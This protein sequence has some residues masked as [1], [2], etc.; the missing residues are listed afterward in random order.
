MISHIRCCHTVQSLVLL[1]RSGVLRCCF[2]LVTF[3]VKSVL[4]VDSF[5]AATFQL[6]RLQEQVVTLK[7]SNENLQRQN[8]DMIGKLKEVCW[9]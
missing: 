6:N 3:L 5:F 8:E 1:K 4:A 7:T 9:F 2:S